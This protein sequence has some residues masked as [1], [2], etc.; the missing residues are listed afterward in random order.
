MDVPTQ[1]SSQPRSFRVIPVLD[2][3][4]GLVVR[5]VAGQRSRYQP[6]KSCLSASCQ[7]IDIAKAI[8][9]HYDCQ[10]FYVADLDALRGGEVQWATLRELL[11]LPIR[12]WVDAGVSDVDRACELSCFDANSSHIWQ[13]IVATE[14]L[15]S[16]EQLSEIVAAVGTQRVAF[17]LDLVQGR[18]RAGSDQLAETDPCDMI[19]HVAQMGV[20][21]PIV[22]DV[23]QVGLR[24]GVST[25]KLCQHIRGAVSHMEIYSGGGVRGRDDLQRLIDVGCTGALVATSLHDGTLAPRDL[26]CCTDATGY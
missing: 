8:H 15:A 12:L 4:G 1:P 20:T 3:M 19:R 25:L 13:V 24:D 7:P 11:R 16:L 18:L 22:L 26:A 21:R 10:E 5:G 9:N 14:T 17:S 6:I 2:L 23:A